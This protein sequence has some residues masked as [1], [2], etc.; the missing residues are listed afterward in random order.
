MPGRTTYTTRLLS[1]S[2]SRTLWL[3]GQALPGA[4][5]ACVSAAIAHDQ[6]IRFGR[7]NARELRFQ[8]DA[9]I[10]ELLQAGFS[11]WPTLAL[12]L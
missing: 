4:V 7:P 11:K 2:V 12:T 8:L 3:F 9:F 1:G 6:S 5:L 10:I